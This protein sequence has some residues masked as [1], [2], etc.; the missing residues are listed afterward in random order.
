MHTSVSYVIIRKYSGADLFLIQDAVDIEASLQHD[1]ALDIGVFGNRA[2][3][4]DN[5]AEDLVRM[6]VDILSV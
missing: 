2:K 6:M 3:L 1:G 5:G 4:G